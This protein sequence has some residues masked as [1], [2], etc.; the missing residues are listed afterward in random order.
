MSVCATRPLS[1]CSA[2]VEHGRTAGL[3]LSKTFA[4]FFFSAED[5]EGCQSRR[6]R[7]AGTEARGC[8]APPG[9][10]PGAGLPVCRGLRYLCSYATAASLS[11]SAHGRARVL[12]HGSWPDQ[13]RRKEEVM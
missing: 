11:V 7:G 12:L 5:G 6:P 2:E 1:A 8:Q 3:V 13:S 4:T 10:H 9:P